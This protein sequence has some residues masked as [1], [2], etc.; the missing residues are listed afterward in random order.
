M[1]NSQDPHPDFKNDELRG[2]KRRGD[3]GSRRE[4]FNNLT[5]MLVNQLHLTNQ[6]AWKP[7]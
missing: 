1:Q 3:R 4:S 7:L 5:N 2:K 6:N